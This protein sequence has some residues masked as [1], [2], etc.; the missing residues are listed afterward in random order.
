MIFSKAI[1]SILSRIFPKPKPIEVRRM[2]QTTMTDLKRY[3]A[4][5]GPIMVHKVELNSM[6][7]LHIE[8]TTERARQLRQQGYYL[9]EV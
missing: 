8:L 5:N 1:D 6:S 9:R 4:S 7:F 2:Y 3:V